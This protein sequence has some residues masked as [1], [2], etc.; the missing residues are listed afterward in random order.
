MSACATMRKARTESEDIA[1]GSDSDLTDA[2]A[3][4]A[5]DAAAEREKGLPRPEF[6]PHGDQ[7][8]S[9]DDIERLVLMPTWREVLLDLVK[10]EQFDPWN[11]DIEAITVAYV[12]RVK[13]MRSMDLHVPSNII[14][15]AAI[16]L[17]LKS[18]LLQLETEEQVAE[19]A[20]FVEGAPAEPVEVSMLQLRVRVPPRRAITLT[21]VI[22][23]LEEVIALEKRREERARERLPSVMELEIPT[24]NIE[25]EMQ[26]MLE[27]AKGLADSEG[28]LTFSQLIPDKGRNPRSIV[29]TLLP[30]LHLVQEGDFHVAQEKIFGEIFIKVIDRVKD[31]ESGQDV[32]DGGEKA[33]MAIAVSKTKGSQKKL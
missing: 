27:K 29:S 31:R 5:V 16:L 25:K 33:V 9:I 12:E 8:Q 19:S 32:E 24:Y 26:E 11:I 22:N 17:R 30:V 18:E 6:R 4:A 7:L 2:V 10:T 1:A 21:D 28:W 15:A 23:A 13:K 20:V 3:E 14:L